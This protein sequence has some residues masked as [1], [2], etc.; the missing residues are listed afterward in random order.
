[1][2]RHHE[3]GERDPAQPVSRD[4]ASEMG[5]TPDERTHRERHNSRRRDR[6][7]AQEREWELAEQDA[8]L[9]RE[10]PLL[11]RNLY[12]DFARALNTPS[13][14]GGVL[15]QIADGLPWTPRHGGLSAAAYL[16]GQSSSTSRPPAEQPASCHQQ[17][18]RRAEQHQRFT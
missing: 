5:E 15:A 3:A 17:S 10:N 18:T 1:M 11:A 8:R 9:Q 14:I 13:E 16:G 6:R 12:P 4:E 2:R 7:Q